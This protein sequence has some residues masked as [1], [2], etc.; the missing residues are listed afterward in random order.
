MTKAQTIAISV[1]NADRKP[2]RVAVSARVVGDFALHRVVNLDG[3]E[4]Q[5][6]RWTISHVP[7]GASIRSALPYVS[8]KPREGLSPMNAYLTW[9]SAVQETHEY[10]MWAQAMAEA[11]FGTEHASNV[12]GR[13]VDASRL[14]AAKARSI[15]AP[16][17]A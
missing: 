7:T 2:T 6:R 10:R 17:L 13:A 15:D 9:M 3:T 11:P 14:F 4:R 1:Y 8:G 16:F 5:P 12:S